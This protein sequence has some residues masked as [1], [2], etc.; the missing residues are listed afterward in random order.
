M[1]AGVD[2]VGARQDPLLSPRPGPR[3]AG[4]LDQ[5]VG[6]APL[7]V[8]PGQ[9]L[10]LRPV[11]DHGRERV[12]DARARIVAVVDRDQRALLV[13]EDAGQRSLR[14]RRQ[15]AVDLLDVGS[16]LDLED[17]VGQRGVE[18]RHP[19]REAVQASLQLGE[20]QPD[21]RRRAGRRRDQREARG[22][23]APKVLVGRIDHGLGVG[24]VVKRGDRAMADADPLVDRLDDRRQAVGRAGGG[25]E[26]VVPIG[27]VAVVVHTDD[28][29]QRRG[30]L[31]RSRDDHLANAL[32]EVGL[33]RLHGPKLARALEHDLDSGVTPGNGA[34]IG[35]AGVAEPC[36]V[37]REGVGLSLR[38]LRPAA[39][40]RVEHQEVGRRR[41]VPVQLV[42]VSESQLGPPPGRPER[43]PPHPAEAVDADARHVATIAC[44]LTL[45]ARQPKH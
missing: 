24:Q 38:A 5:A 27:L 11:D 19:H 1:A 21:R 43:E 10:D 32:P 15:Q 34:G 6:V 7:V 2:R 12:D 26:D 28:H 17:A 41:R 4:Q 33:E 18:H 16:A 9:D 37:D 40:D 31:H 20:D 45:I 22:A 29:V 23:G 36:A 44:R 8:V 14:R 42:D 3:R 25:G 39:M 35:D 13:A 30:L